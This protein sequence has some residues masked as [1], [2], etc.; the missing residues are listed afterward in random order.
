MIRVRK[1]YT[2][3]PTTNVLVIDCLLGRQVSSFEL[4]FY[5]LAICF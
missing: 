2:Y 3:P 5:T 1:C 4:F